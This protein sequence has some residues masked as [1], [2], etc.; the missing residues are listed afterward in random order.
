M[1]FLIEE[2][3]TAYLENEKPDPKIIKRHELV[4]PVT[5]CIEGEILPIEI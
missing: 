1:Q 4:H 5:R 3:E 2:Q